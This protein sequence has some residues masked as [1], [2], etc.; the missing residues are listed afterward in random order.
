MGKEHNKGLL[1][2]RFFDSV[3]RRDSLIKEEKF[4]SIDYPTRILHRDDKL[5]ELA[6]LYSSMITHA[7]SRGINQ[8][9]LGERGI[10]KT[11]TVRYFGTELENTALRKGIN[12]KYLHINCRKERTEYKAL[13]K[14]NKLINNQI[15]S[16]GYS[17]QDL[18]DFIYDHLEKENMFLLLVLDELDY[19]LVKN[20]DFLYSLLRMYEDINSSLP[21]K[22]ISII[23][24]LREISF[25]KDKFNSISSYFPVNSIVFDRYTKQETFDILKHR[26]EISLKKG[27]MS[28]EII[29]KIADIIF[30][31]GDIRCGLNL[32]WHATKIAE[33]KGLSELTLGCVNCACQELVPF[34]IKDSLSNMSEHKLLFLFSIIERSRRNG[35][36]VSS[37]AEVLSEYREICKSTG[38]SPHSYS[39]LWNY[40]RDCELDEILKLKVCGKGFKGRK[41]FVEMPDVPLIRLSEN[42][43]SI[44]QSKGIA[45]IE[46]AK[47]I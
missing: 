47:V 34:T 37:L 38:I 5:N 39:Q 45:V 11:A 18:L 10:G 15:A 6:L 44:L 25:S 42:I 8:I 33:N 43:A 1:C 19:F 21:I 24:I 32:L 31:G 26:A 16:R 20:I 22:R 13:V 41:T 35:N 12:L 23:G 28:D 46:N 3:L 17:P 36:T 27:V 9:V 29:E 7:G 30:R 14:I 40:A 2:G 4:L